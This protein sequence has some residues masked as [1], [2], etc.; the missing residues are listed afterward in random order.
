MFSFLSSTVAVTL[1]AT[2]AIEKV[3]AKTHSMDS[4]FERSKERIGPPPSYFTQKQDHFDTTNTQTWQQAYYVNATY[5]TPGSDAPVF[6]CVGGEGPP[7]DG[8]V[9]VASPHCN[10]AVEWLEETKAIMFAVEH[11]YYGCHN[12]S[13]CP[14][15]QS[16]QHPLQFLSSRQAI[17]DLAEFHAFASIAYNLSEANKWVSFGGSYPGMLAGWFRVKHP[18]LVHASVASSAPVKAILDMTGYNDVT[19]EAYTVESVGGS[20]ECSSA[21]A[22]GHAAVG[23]LFTSAQ[24]RETLAKQFHVSAA[25]LAT[26]EG[27]LGFAGFGVAQFPAQSNDPACTNAGCNIEL[28]CEIMINSSIGDELARLAHLRSVQV[29]SGVLQTKKSHNNAQSEEL[30]YWGYQTC[31]EFGFYQTCEIGSNCFYTQGVDLLSDNDKFC[32]T[33]YGISEE[34]IQKNINISNDFYGAGHPNATR[35][36]YP[37]GE[38]DPW[39]SQGILTSPGPDLPVMLVKGASHHA[40]THPSLPTDQATVVQARIDI[41]KQ[42]AA[43]LKE[44]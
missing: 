7:L 33:L 10:V 5:W 13:A 18:E 15:K 23:K 8:S 41:K 24:G 14:Y 44:K 25:I 17:E 27:Q 22:T 31:T 35:I 11:R 1:F 26:H 37:N 19:T 39:K 20:K 21:I 42:V 12:M 38:V 3:A 40:W 9:V 28:I 29:D 2:L 43:W 32:K 30:D 6:L 36:L 16:D 34:Q 4:V